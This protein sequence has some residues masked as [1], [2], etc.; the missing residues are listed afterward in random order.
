[1][2]PLLP[3]ILKNYDG[4]DKCKIESLEEEF[5]D[6]L[7]SYLTRTELDP[8]QNYTREKAFVHLLETHKYDLILELSSGTEHVIYPE[9]SRDLY[10]RFALKY[11]EKRIESNKYACSKGNVNSVHGKLIDV[12]N[13]RFGVPMVSVGLSCCKMPRQ[14]DIQYVWRN[15]LKGLM[16]FVLLTET[17]RCFI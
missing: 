3:K 4:T 11:Q 13:E 9:I 5:G 14:Q 17:G 15:N 10:E 2:D 8:L 7:Y 1:M 12:L 6:R 16:E